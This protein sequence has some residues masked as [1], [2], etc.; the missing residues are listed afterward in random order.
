[1]TNHIKCGMILVLRGAKDGRCPRTNVP[2]LAPQHG[3]GEATQRGVPTRASKTSSLK[4][5]TARCVG[6]RDINV[7]QSRFAEDNDGL[8][9]LQSKPLG[10]GSIAI[11][12]R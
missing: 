11:D 7:N 1:M 3:E 2:T 8:C 10:G 12:G 4:T 6:V 5:P 9:L